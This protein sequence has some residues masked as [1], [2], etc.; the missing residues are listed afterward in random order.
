MEALGPHLVSPTSLLPGE[1]SVSHKLLAM[2]SFCSFHRVKTGH[3]INGNDFHSSA[4][5]EGIIVVLFSLFSFCPWIGGEISNASL[6]IFLQAQAHRLPLK[7]RCSVMRR[8][9]PKASV[10][11]NSRPM[12]GGRFCKDFWFSRRNPSRQA[13]ATKAPCLKI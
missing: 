12:L 4:L 13:P 9:F 7:K 5:R 8:S 2:D 11:L 6:C 3:L 1:Q 10:L